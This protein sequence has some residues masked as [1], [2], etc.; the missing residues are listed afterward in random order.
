M[1]RGFTLVE[2]LVVIVI[3]GILSLITYPT[4]IKVVNDSKNS[5]YESQV[6]IV[7]KAAKEFAVSNPLVVPTIT[8]NGDSCSCEQACIAIDDLVDSGYLSGDEVKN[9]KGGILNGGVEITCS[10]KA[11]SSCNTCKYEYKYNDNITCPEIQ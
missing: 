2:I 7:E 3:I 4:I 10:C 5:A 8:K 1:K 9:P 11:G 6:K